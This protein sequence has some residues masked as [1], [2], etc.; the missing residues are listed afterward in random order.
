MKF[1][2]LKQINSSFEP[3]LS[4][5]ISVVVKSGSYVRGKTVAEFE[6]AYASY[7]GT[8]HCVGVGNGLDALRL[9]FRSWILSGHM[10][11]GDEVIVPANTYIASILA[12]TE[13][14]LRPVFVEP[15]P[16][17]F[18]IDLDLVESRITSR[19]R[20]ILIVHLYGRNAFSP[21]IKNIAE[22][23]RLKI[24]EDNA[25]AAGCFAGTSRTGCA[26]DAAA[27]SFFPT[28]N[29]GALGD[30]GAVT[31]NNGPL[32]DAIRTLGNYGSHSRAL[33]SVQGINSRLDELQA[34]VLNVKLPRLDADND[35]RRAIAQYYRANI[36]NPHIMLPA[37]PTVP[38]EH[39]WHL[40]VVR[41]ARRD[42]LQQFLADKGVETLVHYPVPPHRQPAYSEMKEVSLP[43]TE[44][45]HREVLSLPLYPGLDPSDI[46][47]IAQAVNSFNP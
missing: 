25:Q 13:N 34:A 17:T 38:S 39:V 40:F 3:A 19:T 26:G 27:H 4:D 37:P 30:A 29:L 15:D 42:L 31:T 33:N 23:H 32:A 6:E 14:R 8:R 12:I 47:K 11:E 24:V 1:L 35:A 45:I 22:R 36:T 5:A 10:S 18:N 2:D 7:I 9:I 41:C 46:R 16:F 28:K 20:A 21:K 44:R 43:V